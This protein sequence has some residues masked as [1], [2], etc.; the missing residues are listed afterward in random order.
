MKSKI[1]IIAFLLMIISATTTW[2]NEDIFNAYRVRATV[3]LPTGNKTASGVYPY[4]GIIA[5][6]K[7]HLGQIAALYTEDMEFIGYFECKD[8]GGHKGLKNG[9]R[10]DV[11]RESEASYKAWVKKYGDYVYIQ[12]IDGI[13]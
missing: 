5:A 6:N 7:E 2:A 11:Y 3:Y 1:T 8:T 13:G 4:E 12:W 9:T 10:I